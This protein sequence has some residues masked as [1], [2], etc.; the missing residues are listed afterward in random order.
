MPSIKCH[1]PNRSFSSLRGGTT[2]SPIIHTRDQGPHWTSPSVT[3]STQ[4]GCPLLWPCPSFF[5]CAGNRTHQPR[6][7]PE[8]EF[9][10]NISERREMIRTNTF[11]GSTLGKKW[12]L[13]LWTTLKGWSS[14][15]SRPQAVVAYPNC[16]PGNPFVTYISQG[17][18]LLSANGTEKQLNNHHNSAFNKSPS[19]GQ[20]YP[21][22]CSRDLST[23]PASPSL[24]KAGL[25][26]H[27][28]RCYSFLSSFWAQ[29]IL[30]LLYSSCVPG[31]SSQNQ[32]LTMLLLCFESSVGPHCP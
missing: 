18:F 27:L 30:L 22:P 19:P 5:H 16:L 7:H 10:V 8:I 21:L 32:Y 14:L 23:L 6:L 9:W 25:L 24:F 1:S 29:L 12:P 15:L 11:Y 26:F 20:V 31:W 3:P 2:I 13:R 28:S 4:L 17:H